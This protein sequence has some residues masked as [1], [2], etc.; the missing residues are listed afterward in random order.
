MDFQRDR[1]VH[2]LTQTVSVLEYV[3]PKGDVNYPLDWFAKNPGMKPTAIVPS[4]RGSREDLIN[5]VKGGIR[6]STLTIQTVKIFLHRF[7]ETM[8][9]NVTKEWISFGE[10]IGLPG[11]EV[12]P[13][14]IVTITEGP[15]HAPREPMYRPVQ[16]GQI[17]GPDD[18]QNWTELS[19][20]L[21]IVCIYRLARLSNDEYADLL[22]KRMD[23]QVRAEGGR[24]IS[25]HGARNIYSSWLSD[26]HF[27]KMVAAMD[28]FLY[29]FNNHA[30]A[31]LRMGTLGS[32]FRDCAGL[33]SF[34]Y[35]MN[36][37]NV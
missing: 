25:F 27:V 9:E 30:A 35:A 6:G 33:L 5:S 32:R 29:R 14:S 24:G 8:S 34:G 17:T 19:M 3:D 26:L 12:T 11:D 4:Y 23:D 16:A 28:M 7:G 37:L 15:V 1:S 20:A 31:I 22:Q 36:I 13:W 21:F 18:P 2:I 10:E